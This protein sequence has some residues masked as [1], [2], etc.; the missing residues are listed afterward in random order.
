VKARDFKTQIVGGVLVV[1]LGGAAYAYWTASGSGTGTAATAAG[2]SVVVVQTSSATGLYPGGSVALSGN[3]NNPNAG[4]VVI[5]SVTAAVHA[6]STQPD[7]TKPACTQAD[8]SITGTSNNPG[9]I[10][11]GNGVGAWSGLT[12]NMANSGT[13][14]DNC[15]SLASIQIDYTAA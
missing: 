8:F 6:F 5:T 4:A 11:A 13:N 3:F 9:S 14:Q 7:N 10:A 15:K 12:L 2:T 1:L